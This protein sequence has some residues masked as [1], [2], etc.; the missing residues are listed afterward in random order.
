VRLVAAAH[1]YLD[2]RTGRNLIERIEDISD[3]CDCTLPD[4]QHDVVRHEDASAGRSIENSYHRNARS[5]KRSD[6][7]ALSENNAEPLN[8]PLRSI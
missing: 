8:K 4:T 2:T 3:A 1:D 6:D 7:N 5:R